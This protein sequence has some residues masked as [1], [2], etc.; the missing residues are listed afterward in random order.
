[1]R[2]NPPN[3]F[4]EEYWRMRERMDW[5]CA[6]LGRGQDIAQAKTVVDEFRSFY[7]KW[8]P[9]IQVPELGKGLDDLREEMEKN[10]G[11]S[12]ERLFLAHLH[13]VVEARKDWW[14]AEQLLKLS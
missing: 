4:V 10:L 1:M 12:L 6:A 8:R 5:A 3:E 2:M 11:R 9:V 7:R 13:E 14:M